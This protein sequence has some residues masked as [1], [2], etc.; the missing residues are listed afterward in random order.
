MKKHT[1]PYQLEILEGGTTDARAIQ[2]TRIGS[3]RAVF[4]SL[5]LYSLSSE[6]WISGM[7]ENAV[8]LLLELI[9]KPVKLDDEHSVTGFSFN[10][11]SHQ[12]LLCFLI[13]TLILLLVMGCSG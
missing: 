5:P 6:W 10:T 11:F 3:P 1:W 4:P 8:R 7:V 9:S 2:L 12:L 13:L